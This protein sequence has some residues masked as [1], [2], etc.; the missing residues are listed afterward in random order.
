MRLFYHA[1]LYLAI[2]IFILSYFPPIH[3]QLSIFTLK[4]RPMG[5][6]HRITLCFLLKNKYYNLPLGIHTNLV[7]ALRTI[8]KLSCTETGSH[9]GQSTGRKN[10]LR[11][12]AKRNNV[13][14]SV[15][16]FIM[17]SSLCPIMIQ[18]QF[19]KRWRRDSYACNPSAHKNTHHRSCHVA[20]SAECEFTRIFRYIKYTAYLAQI[21]NRFFGFYRDVVVR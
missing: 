3:I 13:P 8:S 14:V 9:T 5:F 19:F 16:R 7:H 6:I 12:S 17:N 2:T 4:K 1:C 11:R 21:W 18:K 10:G 15:N 20:V